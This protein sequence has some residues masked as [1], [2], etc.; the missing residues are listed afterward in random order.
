MEPFLHMESD[1]LCLT[2]GA[3]KGTHSRLAQCFRDM[4]EARTISEAKLALTQSS[5]MKMGSSSNES[6]RSEPRH[7]DHSTANYGG[8]RRNCLSVFVTI[9]LVAGLTHWVAGR[10]DAQQAG[11]ASRDSDAAS[12][13][14]ESSQS[15]DQA[16]ARAQAAMEAERTEEAIGLYERAVA[17][18]PSFSEGWWE[19]G[20]TFFDEGQIAKAHDAF[21][22]FVSE[23]HRQ[24]GPGFGML[25]LTEFELKDYQ[26]AIIAFERGRHLGL[27]DNAG[28][29]ER[30]YYEDGVANNY[31]GQYEIAVARLKYAA[32]K[33]A[34][35]NHDAPKEAV[36]ADTDLINAFGVAALHIPKIP[37]DIPADK[38]EMI[39]EAGNAQALIAMQDQAAAGQELKQFVALY[40]KE[41]G[42]HYM[43]GVYLLKEDRLSAIGEFQR[44]IEVAPKYLPAYI[45]I[46]LEDLKNGDYQEGLKYAQKAIALAP[47]NFVAHVAC[48]RLWLNLNN[49]DSALKELR[50]AVKLSPNSPDA[51][52]ALSR[53]LFRSGN[54]PE[55]AKEQ[56]EFER[57]K[58]LADAADRE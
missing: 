28:F 20:T 16:V 46:A 48:G 4:P 26:K 21:L 39:H 52:F 23:E 15:F 56:A 51:H 38:K 33:I 44:E 24:P 6:T 25:G 5:R 35:E 49:T 37:S 8:G 22:H 14:G 47:T 57:L 2:Y 43:Y 27:G 31:L 50:I 9:A 29:I 45:Q 42:V 32:E 10:A 34:Y 13:T 1:L 41:P 19:L 18:K 40:P 12:Q 58:A 36:L 30:V 53:A 11:S 3:E 17:L 7:K 54:K 55:A